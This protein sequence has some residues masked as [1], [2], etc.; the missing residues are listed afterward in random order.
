MVFHF[1]KLFIHFDKI[2]SKYKNYLFYYT[3]IL[4]LLFDNFVKK[5]KKLHF[6]INL[7]S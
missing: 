7:Q 5:L 2:I 6:T 1:K 3:F 4:I